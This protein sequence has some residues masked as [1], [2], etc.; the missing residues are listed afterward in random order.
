MFHRN[1]QQGF[2]LLDVMGAVAIF[3]LLIPGILTFMQLTASSTE[4]KVAAQQMSTIA[5]AAEQYVRDNHSS[6]VSSATASTS[7][8]I[9][10][11]DLQSGGYLASGYGGNNPWNQ[12]YSIHAFNPNANDI[13]LVLITTGGR[14]YS[15]SEPQFATRVVPAAAAMMGSQGGY[16]P[17]GDVAGESSSVLQ[18]AFGGWKFDLSGTDMTNPGAGHLA[19]T[20]YIDEEQFGN[21]YLYRDEVPGHSEVNRMTTELD[22]DGNT[23]QM[24]DGD[25]G[26]G[27]GQGARKVNLENHESSDFTC[28]DNDDYGGS[29]FYDRSEGLYVCRQGEKVEIS[30][31]MNSVYLKDASIASNGDSIS[32]PT[33]NSAASSPQ[34][35]V[36]PTFFSADAS[37][38]DIKAVQT[39]ASDSGGSW[40]INLRVLTKDGWVHPNSNYGKVLVMTECS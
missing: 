17:T 13:H 37:G 25:V 31:S 2:A 35:F 33:C 39:W 15:A 38:K 4:K 26:G 23:I 21:D 19:W 10:I 12:S 34:I 22:M 6:I 24:G 20:K 8:N 11:A 7:V 9:S 28:A 40:Q 27:D 18:G 36:A 16:V 1:S 3:A 30:D 14:G 32:K 5:T 29:V